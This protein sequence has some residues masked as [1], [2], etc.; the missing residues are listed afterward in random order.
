MSAKVRATEVF[1]DRSGYQSP[2]A[3]GFDR[4]LRFRIIRRR[5]VVHN[6][7]RA[8]LAGQECPYPLD[9][10]ADS[11]IGRGEKLD[12]DSGPSEPGREPAQMD[13]TTLQNSKPFAH[14]CHVAFV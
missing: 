8:A 4:S 1:M 6:Q 7:T 11:E 14:Y 12:M 13:L 9:K 10:N 5:V 3:S 2:V